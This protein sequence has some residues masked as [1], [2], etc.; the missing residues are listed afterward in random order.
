MPS[1]SNVP[2]TTIVAAGAVKTIS[3]KR[4]PATKPTNTTAAASSQYIQVSPLID[5]PLSC[6]K[7]HERSNDLCRKT[8]VE[9]ADVV[10][11][12]DVDVA[13][14]E[15]LEMDLMAPVATMEVVIGNEGIVGGLSGL[16]EVAMAKSSAE[17]RIVQ[18]FMGFV[19]SMKTE[20][21]NNLL[22]CHLKTHAIVFSYKRGT[23]LS[24]S[25][26]L[27]TANLNFTFNKNTLNPSKNQVSAM[28]S[29]PMTTS[30]VATGAVKSI[31]NAKRPAASASTADSKTSS[32]Q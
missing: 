30:I 2:M 21:L 15:R 1:F 4:T 22:P 25:L 5:L 24:V 27:V 8:I 13:G 9:F 23:A 26:S 19:K 28:P 16:V 6:I 14:D 12:V 3:S 7:D 31:T 17:D 10:D 20:R 11:V 29:F 18:G 32:N